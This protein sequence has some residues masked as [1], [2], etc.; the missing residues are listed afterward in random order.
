MHDD[1]THLRVGSSHVLTNHACTNNNAHSRDTGSTGR[2]NSSANCGCRD[3]TTPYHLKGVRIVTGEGM[4]VL[5]QSFTEEEKT[6][7]IVLV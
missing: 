3:S 5:Y 6:E 4:G 1:V 7:E 2:R